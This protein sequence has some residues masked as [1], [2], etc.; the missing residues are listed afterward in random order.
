MSCSRVPPGFEEYETGFWLLTLNCNQ[1]TELSTKVLSIHLCLRCGRH[2]NDFRPFAP[3]V[4]V[5]PK[6]EEE[7]VKILMSL[8]NFVHY[9]MG[10]RLDAPAC[11]DESG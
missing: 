5:V 3:F 2:E 11:L 6:Q 10:V 1:I 9:N 7:T 4:V 8:M